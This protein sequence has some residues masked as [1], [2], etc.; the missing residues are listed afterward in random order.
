MREARVNGF[1]AQQSK[2]GTSNKMI[3][4]LAIVEKHPENDPIEG[5]VCLPVVYPAIFFVVF[6]LHRYSIA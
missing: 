1:D 6:V 3:K 4:S 5:R 2:S